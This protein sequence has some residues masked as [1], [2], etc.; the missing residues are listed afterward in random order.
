VT[1]ATLAPAETATEPRARFRDF[2]AAEWLKFWTLRSTPWFLA[3][4]AL[5]VLALN[6]GSAYQSYSYWHQNHNSPARFIAQGIPLQDAFNTNAGVALMILASA[7]GA[8]AITGEYSTGLIRTT[9]TAVPA[10]RSVMAAKVCV[11]TAVLTVFGVIV[12]FAS[13]GLTQAILSGRH[14]GVSLSYPGALQLVVA[15]A[16]F[17]PLSALVGAAIGAI[18]R[19]S[20]A[21]VAASF[22]ILLVVPLL[23]R[24][25][26]HL[27]AIINHA[28]PY[29]AWNRLVAVP[30]PPAGTA[31]PWTATGAWIVFAFWAVVA[32]VLTVIIVQYRD[33]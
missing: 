32:A 27:P 4:S 17:A 14:A 13:F 22:V 2:I 11:I 12:A 1:T 33:V 24:D 29:G 25:G 28:L 21:A 20:A 30:Y 9:F 23:I 6:G 26:S 16:L 18:V 5:V 3:V 8:L 31:Y 15:S 19:H 7:I 10:R